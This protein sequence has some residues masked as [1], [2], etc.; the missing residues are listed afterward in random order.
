MATPHEL[1]HHWPNAPRL[2]ENPQ[3]PVNMMVLTSIRDVG[4]CD[5]NG[6]TIRTPEGWPRMEGAVE[7]L[8]NET[9]RGG[10]LSDHIHVTGII[11]DDM[12]R[13]MADSD[14]PV[15]W[16]AES[17]WIH[18]P[19]LQN[20]DGVL[21]RSPDFTRNIPSDFRL[22]NGL[23]EPER[24][25][26]QKAAFEDKIATFMQ[27]RNTQV[28]LSDHYMAR[29]D[30]LIGEAHGMYGRVLNIHPAITLAEHPYCR[31]GKT[32]TQD[33]IDQAQNDPN[34]ITGATLHF[35]NNL[36]DDGPPISHFAGTPVY[37]RDKP[38]QLRYRNY[39]QAKLPLL[40][41]GLR[42]YIENIFPHLHN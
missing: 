6:S 10:F 38:Q 14:Y 33:S 15:E 21:I 32:P 29:I 3:E 40:I 34:T 9:R 12:D 8:I 31:R 39:Q 20:D 25:A 16:N 11:T 28:L 27:E 2:P 7:R 24:K 4:T 18:A 26:G 35:I 30:Y 1:I 42:H 5:R 22:I 17:P 19:D 23:Q 41:F 13:D 37:R 36:I